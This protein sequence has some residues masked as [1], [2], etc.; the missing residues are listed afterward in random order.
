MLSRFVVML[1]SSKPITTLS[2]S[3]DD[4]GDL[5]APRKQTCEKIVLLIGKLFV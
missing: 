4:D 2:G 1:H 3:L 5:V